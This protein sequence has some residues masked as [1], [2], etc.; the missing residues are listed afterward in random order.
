MSGEGGEGTGQ[1]PE[2]KGRN[3]NWTES[4]I[5]TTVHKDRT[6]ILVSHS[7]N[8]KQ[9]YSLT[10]CPL[11]CRFIRYNNQLAQTHPYICIAFRS[12]LTWIPGYRVSL[13]S[14]NTSE[15]WTPV[16]R[17]DVIGLEE[18]VQKLPMWACP[19]FSF[20]VSSGNERFLSVSGVHL[21][22]TNHDMLTL[23]DPLVLVFILFITPT[24]TFM[25]LVLTWS[26]IINHSFIL[27]I[28]S[29]V[30]GS[31]W[32]GIMSQTQNFLNQHHF[33]KNT[34]FSKVIDRNSV[35]PVIVRTMCDV[36]RTIKSDTFVTDEENI[37]S[38]WRAEV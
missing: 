29:T 24:P 7:L 27:T 34:D 13:G 37:V 4:E 19:N 28:G 3:K 16:S 17:P 15:R 33:G 26:V 6:S 2:K 35:S 22:E 12:I 10:P 9:M 18:T 21:T 36:S 38:L 14:E 31:L 32:T 5:M 1:N 25:Y 20:S 30:S 8:D 23:L 11:R